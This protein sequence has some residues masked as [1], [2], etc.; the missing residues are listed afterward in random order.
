M[1]IKPEYPNSVAMPTFL[2]IARVRLS[3]Y[4]L[5]QT[6]EEHPAEQPL[7]DSDIIEAATLLCIL[8]FLIMDIMTSVILGR[9]KA[10]LTIKLRQSAIFFTSFTV[11]SFLTSLVELGLTFVAIVEMTA[12][13]VTLPQWCS[14]VNCQILIAILALSWVFWALSVFLL[15]F[16]LG[17]VLPVYSAPFRLNNSEVGIPI[18][19]LPSS[20]ASQQ[21]S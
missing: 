2:Y 6:H 4:L 10:R 5:S 9:S 12:L 16:E 21:S 15:G 8:H 11:V 20:P 13:Y 3:N 7:V 1:S 19:T 18:R 17:F 14:N